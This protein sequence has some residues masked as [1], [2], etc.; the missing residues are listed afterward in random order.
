[1]NLI[2]FLKQQLSDAPH[3]DGEQRK[4]VPQQEDAELQAMQESRLCRLQLWPPLSRVQTRQEALQN[5]QQVAG[6][7]VLVQGK[8]PE[9]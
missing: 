7:L 1:M 6:V 3:Q 9:R 4:L 5:P 2:R 8:G